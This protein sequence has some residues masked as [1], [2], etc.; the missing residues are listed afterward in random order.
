M[1]L[2]IG[3]L[4]QLAEVNVETIR[5]YERIGLL[6]RPVKPFGGFRTYPSESARRIRFIK[7]AQQLGFSLKEVS[8]LLLLG[9]GQCDRVRILAEQKR[10]R[11]ASRINDLTAMRAVLDEL[12]EC[13][14]NERST[15]HCS[16]ID[17]LSDQPPEVR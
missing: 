4:A 14:L 1:A 15:Q 17:S 16:L 10:E 2:T 8:E 12:I 7:R 6:N 9:E 11:I 3:K 13:C 5:Y